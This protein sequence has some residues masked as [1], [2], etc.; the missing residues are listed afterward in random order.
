MPLAVP[1]LAAYFRGNWHLR[2]RLK[3][4]MKP[5]GKARG[6]ARFVPAQGG[7]LYREEVRLDLAGYGGNANR[8]YFYSLAQRGMADVF[9][10][11]GRPFH[12]LD[13]RDGRFRV[14]HHCGMD[15]YRGS[16][17]VLDAFRWAVCWRASG[18][19]KKFRTVTLYERQSV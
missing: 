15:T 10:N 2:R 7:L 3:L 5:V 1:D 6:Q 13:L 11:D 14:E 17:R 9:F 19:H 4:D 8:D 16:F 12:R 18:P